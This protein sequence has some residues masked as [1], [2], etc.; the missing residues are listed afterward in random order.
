VIDEKD[1][2]FS[3]LRLWVD[4]NHDGISQPD[5][6]HPLPEMGVFSISPDYSLARYIDEFGNVFRYRAKV[7]PE[8]HGKS[9]VGQKIYDVFFV[10]K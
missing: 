7:N 8:E 5:E 9:D 3:S 10:N 2:I 6:L 4:A 1:A